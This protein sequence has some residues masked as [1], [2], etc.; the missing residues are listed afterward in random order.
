MSA[1]TGYEKSQLRI[2]RFSWKSNTVV[3]YAEHMLYHKRTKTI[4]KW[5]WIGISIVIIISM[6][7]AYSG[8][9]GIF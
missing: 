1:M 6:V 2:F 5:M 4:M 8:G 7:F 9:S 3:L